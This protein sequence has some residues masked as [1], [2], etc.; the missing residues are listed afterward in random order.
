VH[1]GFVGRKIGDHREFAV[2]DARLP[3]NLELHDPAHVRD[4]HAVEGESHVGQLFLTIGD[5]V[6]AARATARRGTPVAL[7]EMGELRRDLGERHR[8]V[9]PVRELGMRPITE[10]QKVDI[11][12]PRLQPRVGNPS[13]GDFDFTNDPLEFGAIEFRLDLRGNV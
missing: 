6:Q 7:H 9:R 2:E 12:G 11:D 8:V 3:V 4:A 10:D 13:D 1:A 5:E